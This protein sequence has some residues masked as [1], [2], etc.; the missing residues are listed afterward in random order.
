MSTGSSSY[1]QLPSFDELMQ[2]AKQDPTAFDELKANMCVACIE[3]ASPDMQ[4]RLRAQQSHIDL[5]VSRSKNPIHANVLLRKELLTQFQKFREA[6][7]GECDVEKEA[8]IV[9]FKSKTE[10]WR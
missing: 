4:L 10:D 6:L 1:Q 5:I 7:C 3:S 8:E 2:L 9:P